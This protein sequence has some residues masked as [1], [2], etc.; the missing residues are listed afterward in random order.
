MTAARPGSGRG[1]PLAGA[2]GVDIPSTAPAVARR[3]CWSQVVPVIGAAHRPRSDVVY[4]HLVVL[5]LFAADAA[6]PVVALPK[7]ASEEKTAR[8]LIHQGQS[9]ISQPQVGVGLDARFHDVRHS[10][11]ARR[12]RRTIRLFRLR[13]SC[14]AH[15]VSAAWR[16]GGNRSMSPTIFSA[17]TSVYTCHS[18]A[19]MVSIWYHSVKLKSKEVCSSRR[20]TCRWGSD[21]VLCRHLSK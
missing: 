4:V 5:D 7:L 1:G 17:M 10:S 15:P 14:L 6:L 20:A 3:V 9:G 2:A 18:L 13:S 16:S 11:T 12:S 21:P 8:L 19:T